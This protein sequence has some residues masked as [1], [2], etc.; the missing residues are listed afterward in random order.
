MSLC[1]NLSN[2]TAKLSVELFHNIGH[3]LLIGFLNQVNEILSNIPALNVCLNTLSNISHTKAYQRCC[4]SAKNHITILYISYYAIVAY[5]AGRCIISSLNLGNKL[6]SKRYDISVTTITNTQRQLNCMRNRTQQVETLY[7]RSSKSVNSLTWVTNRYETASWLYATQKQ[8]S[9]SS[10]QVL[11]LI[12]ENP[13]KLIHTQP[14]Y[15]RQVNHISIIYYAS[16][17]LPPRHSL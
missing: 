8:I 16:L 13:I 1:Y 10:I 14:L 6:F 9:L 4:N 17:T 11:A 12:Y 2:N 15:Y 7:I 5:Y 3:F